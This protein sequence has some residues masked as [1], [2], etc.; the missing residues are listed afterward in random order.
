MCFS[1]NE[2]LLEFLLSLWNKGIRNQTFQIDRDIYIIFL[3]IFWQC[4]FNF[5]FS[6]FLCCFRKMSVHFVIIYIQLRLAHLL[7]LVGDFPLPFQNIFGL[8]LNLKPI[9]KG[10][11]PYST[12][13]IMAKEF[14]LRNNPKGLSQ[15]A[16]QIDVH[17]KRS[18]DGMGERINSLFSI[19]NFMY[20]HH[21]RKVST[22]TH[23][24]KVL[25]SK[26]GRKTPLID[27]A[28]RPAAHCKLDNKLLEVEFQITRTYTHKI[29]KALTYGT[30][31]C[32]FWYW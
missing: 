6:L 16:K 28:T 7:S 8:H 14:D 19:T 17:L 15:Q 12:R 32:R 27:I 3:F 24:E 26:I 11:S 2:R 13:S 5:Q 23:R 1:L 31:Y 10:F 4:G 22:G 20:K 29:R 21:L 9:I 18:K 30:N 25:K